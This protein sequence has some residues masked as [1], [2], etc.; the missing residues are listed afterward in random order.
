MIGRRV[1]FSAMVALAACAA[2]YLMYR[3]AR[4][5][6]VAPELVPADQV[7]VSPRAHADL[8]LS[9]PN[10]PIAGTELAPML[11]AVTEVSP[12]SESRLTPYARTALVATLASYL[13][14]FASDSPDAYMRIATTE[15][16]EWIG[17]TDRAWPLYDHALNSIGKPNADRSS[18]HAA[19][20]TLLRHYRDL[21]TMSRFKSIGTGPRGMRVLVDFGRTPT[22]PDRLLFFERFG[23][24]EHEYWTRGG[25]STN[26]FREPTR[27]VG[28]I[29]R[30]HRGVLFAQAAIL[31]ITPN[32]KPGI[33]HS[34]WYWDPDAEV[35]LNRQSAMRSFFGLGIFY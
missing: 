17:P 27:S 8:L 21:G 18:P 11:D 22:D 3:T 33:W 16:T 4:P 28:S 6:F 32:D 35:W 15:P 10:V 31:V 19:F 20:E 29:L 7:R 12:S 23:L 34:T 30:E 5:R 9:V 1:I 14:A 26:R 25:G 24:D 13:E 2:A